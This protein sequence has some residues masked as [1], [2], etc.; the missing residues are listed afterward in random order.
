VREGWFFAF[1]SDLNGTR[2]LSFVYSPF[3][4]LRHV[5][6]DFK[7][8]FCV[9][10]RTCSGVLFRARIAPGFHLHSGPLPLKT[11]TEKCESTSFRATT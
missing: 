7:D 11:G 1:Q 9:C 10:V 4:S 6:R 5:D 3:S 2:F 8:L